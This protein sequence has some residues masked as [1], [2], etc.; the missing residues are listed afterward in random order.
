MRN[1]KSFVTLVKE[2]KNKN[3][4]GINRFA[5]YLS[6]ILVDESNDWVKLPEFRDYC[7]NKVGE[8]MRCDGKILTAFPRGHN[9]YMMVRIQIN[10]K[11][12]WVSIHRAVATAFIPN[13]EKKP[14]VNH[15]D[16]NKLNNHVDNLEWVTASE[17]QKHAYRT[18]LRK[19]NHERN[20]G[21]FLKGSNVNPKYQKERIE[22]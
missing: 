16:G 12:H 19:P 5:D 10:N 2:T 18:G 22:E 9:K 7:V 8:I 4:I 20:S 13:P 14:M 1:R 17:N 11:A 6:L 3:N 21:I 15:I